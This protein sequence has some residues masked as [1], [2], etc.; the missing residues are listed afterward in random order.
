MNRIPRFRNGPNIT[1]GEVGEKYR[2]RGRNEWGS[3]TR[4]T[5]RMLH[6][7]YEIRILKKKFNEKCSVKE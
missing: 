3:V 7:L 1:G 4:E 2:E 5:T 6:G